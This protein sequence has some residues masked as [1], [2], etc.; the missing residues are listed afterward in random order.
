[1]NKLKNFNCQTYD[2][3]LASNVS[4][5]L[6]GKLSGKGVVLNKNISFLFGKSRRLLSEV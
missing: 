4:V 2:I 6:Q 1:M 5:T 3:N